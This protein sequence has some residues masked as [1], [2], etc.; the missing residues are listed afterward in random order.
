MKLEVKH[1]P[2]F[3]NVQSKSCLVVGGGRVAE[4]KVLMLLKAGCHV[5]VW[6]TQL[7]GRL[8]A[9]AK[10]GVIAYRPE[11]YK[12]RSLGKYHIVIAAT[13]DPQVQEAISAASHKERV[14]VNVVDRPELSDFIA[15][16]VL[17]RGD[18]TV[19]ISTGGASPAMAKRI[20]H[21][22]EPLFGQE[23]AL[24]L[25]ILS[26]LRARLSSRVTRRQGLLRTIVGSPFLERVK[27]GKL[28]DVDRILT[29]VCGPGFTLKELGIKV[30]R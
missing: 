24:A 29:E 20:R 18:L 22:L 17:T 10:K 19:A 9:L 5:T 15:P 11:Y 1:Y 26:R 16:S 28:G 13:D 8:V 23:Y 25:K 30:R 7:T 27:E 3:L 4:R 2:V 6:S 12:R 14:L 21:Q